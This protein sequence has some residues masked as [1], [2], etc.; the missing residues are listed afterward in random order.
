MTVI[1]RLGSLK[2]AYQSLTK[3]RARSILA[4]LARFGDKYL[5]GV[6]QENFELASLVLAGDLGLAE[7]QLVRD[8]P[9]Q[10][11]QWDDFENQNN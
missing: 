6:D 10:I 11:Y 1:A 2:E 7:D 9:D 5:I 4:G 3:L 8:N